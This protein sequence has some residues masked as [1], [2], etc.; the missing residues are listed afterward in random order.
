MTRT[1][2]AQEGD[3][4]ST[5]RPVGRDYANYSAVPCTCVRVRISLVLSP[6]SLTP[7]GGSEVCRE[8][9]KIG[10]LS[11]GKSARQGVLGA[12]PMAAPAEAAWTTHGTAPG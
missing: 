3:V 12:A 5:H 4:L 2:P 9:G 6:L 8:S 1:Q 11:L 7:G 10:G